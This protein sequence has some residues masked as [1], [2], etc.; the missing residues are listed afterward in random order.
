MEAKKKNVKMLPHGV[1][2]IQKS[3]FYYETLQLN[4]A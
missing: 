3:A 1:S 4:K 2:F